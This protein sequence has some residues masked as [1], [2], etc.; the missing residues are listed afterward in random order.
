MQA[1]VAQ[2]LERQPYK[3]DVLGPNPSGRTKSESFL[4]RRSIFNNY[5]NKG[6]YIAVFCSAAELGKK[7]I[8]PA[9][10]FAKLIAENGYHLVWGGSDTG[11]MKVIADEVQASGGDLIGVTIEVYKDV[12]RKNVTE[13][14]ISPSL[15]ERKA[16]MLVRSD[17][18]VVLAGGIG[19]LDEV[20][21]VLELKKQGKHN[22][23]VVLLNTAHFYDGLKIQLQKMQDEGFMHK[24]LG[25][26]I[27][28]A[29]TP[30]EAIDY[31]NRQLG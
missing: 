29:G 3:L 28:F 19:T 15:G 1:S 27:F 13:M 14:I 11:L 23:P 16:T 10:E 12:I 20:T 5:M 2:R 21:E 30:E 4:T 24:P 6:K 26:L 7:Y 18:I 17:A 9:E 8:K 22:K 25:E 31:I